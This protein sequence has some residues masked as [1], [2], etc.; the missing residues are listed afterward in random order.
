MTPQPS[1]IP[2]KDILHADP[3][4]ACDPKG[5]LQ[6]RGIMPLLNG[7]DGLAT[8]PNFTGQRGLAHLPVS[9]AQLANAV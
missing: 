2:A 9:L 4:Y 7:N 3:E 6:T 1:S 5:P 8:D